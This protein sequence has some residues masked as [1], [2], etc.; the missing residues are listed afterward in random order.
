MTGVE[1]LF[2]GREEFDFGSERVGRLGFLLGGQNFADAESC[3][4]GADSCH[5]GAKADGG[6]GGRN[7]GFIE[8]GSHGTLPWCKCDW[9]QWPAVELVRIEETTDSERFTA[10]KPERLATHPMG[11]SNWL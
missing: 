7:C 4:G 1:Q 8:Q 2:A 5:R 3:E 6:V 9:G 10:S 11:G